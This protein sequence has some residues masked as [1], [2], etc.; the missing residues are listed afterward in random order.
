MVFVLDVQG[1]LETLAMRFEDALSLG[2]LAGGVEVVRGRESRQSTDSAAERLREAAASWDW[3]ALSF[4]G[5]SFWD[6]HVGVVVVEAALRAGLHWTAPLDGRIRPLAETLGAADEIHLSPVTQEFQLHLPH[7][8]E[9][10]L[11]DQALGL[12][13]RVTRLLPD[14]V[15]PGPHDR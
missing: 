7:I 2:P 6:L 9:S 13:E 15:H 5:V 14:L 11:A 4:R 3:V 12:A 1:R 10:A 8:S